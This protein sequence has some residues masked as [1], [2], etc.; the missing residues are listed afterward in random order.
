MNSETK[1]EI[2]KKYKQIRKNVDKR[3]EKEQAITDR[4]INII[5]GAATVFCYESI[6]GEVSTHEII[7]RLSEFADVYVPIVDGNSMR[8][9]SREKDE[10]TD[11]PCDY[12]IVP[13]IAFDEKLDRIGFGGGYYDRYLASNVTRSIGIA[14]DEQQC[15]IF[16]T[17][18]TDYRPDMIITPTRILIKCE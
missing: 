7:A 4:L 10:Y 3:D 1:S 2:R 6:S 18:E 16:E 12:T 13:L 8:L 11:M 17:E 5:S 15:E 14:F 9:Y